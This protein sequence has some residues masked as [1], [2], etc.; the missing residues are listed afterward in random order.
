MDPE[1]RA[2]GRKIDRVRI[3]LQR[4]DLLISRT[5]NNV[6]NNQT[7]VLEKVPVCFNKNS[8]ENLTKLTGEFNKTDVRI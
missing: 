3:K 4:S 8:R 2:V 7:D 5:K 6:K 1:E